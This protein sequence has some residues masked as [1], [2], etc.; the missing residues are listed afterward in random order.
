[1]R[2]PAQRLSVVDEMF[3]RAHRGLGTPV[4]MQG[5][6]RG[7]D[8]DDTVLLRIHAALRRSPLGRTVTRAQVPGARPRWHP[9][10]AAWPVEWEPAALPDNHVVTW[11]DGV[12]QRPVDPRAGAGWRLA[13]ARLAGGGTVVSLLCSHALTDARGLA[14]TL[15]SAAQA[16]TAAGAVTEPPTAPTVHPLRDDFADAARMVT[17]V[18]GRTLR[19]TAGLVR[20]PARRRELEPDRLPVRAT[21][22]APRPET[23][24]VDVDAAAW[25][26]AATRFGGTANSLLVAVAV[27][28]TGLDGRVR[29]GVPVDRRTD[30]GD[31]GNAVDM[32]EVGVRADDTPAV[33]RELLRA[34][35]RRPPLSSPAGFPPELLQLVPDRVA[36]RMAPDPGER[37]VLCSNI[38]SVPAALADLGGARATAVATRAVHPGITAE[39]MASSRTR[40]SAYLCRL[41]DRYTLSLVSKDGGLAER[42]AAEFARHDLHPRRW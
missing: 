12:A 8:V 6:W 33:V 35:Y 29:V 3:L 11:A 32:V 15:A 23:M 4:V 38:G 20:H 34:A 25:D 13:A 10:G 7:D 1:M 5:L 31:T 14:R 22:P 42:C 19:A 39:R 30:G 16:A 21:N 18:G 40:L 9:V 17:G 37:D 28:I 36:Y 24:I 26:D 41:G 2:I 27:G